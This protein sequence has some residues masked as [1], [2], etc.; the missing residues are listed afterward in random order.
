MA[1]MLVLTVAVDLSLSIGGHLDHGKVESCSSKDKLFMKV[2]HGEA[3]SCME[4]KINSSSNGQSWKVT[5]LSLKDS[6]TK[7]AD[8][9]LGCV[10]GVSNQEFWMEVPVNIFFSSV[11]HMVGSQFTNIHSTLIPVRINR[12]DDV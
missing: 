10:V 9:C 4:S 8:R 11:L 3:H 1:S 6:K 7:W 12:N 2:W 5:V